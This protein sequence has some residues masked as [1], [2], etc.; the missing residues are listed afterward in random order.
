MFMY[1][2]RMI[3]KIQYNLIINIGNNKNYLTLNN[4]VAVLFMQVPTSYINH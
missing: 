3:I 4:N 2:M 1:N